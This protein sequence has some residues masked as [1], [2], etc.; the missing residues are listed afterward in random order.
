MALLLIAPVLAVCDGKIKDV[1]A[2]YSSGSY[3]DTARLGEAYENAAQCFYDEGNQ[4]KTEYYYTLAANAYSSTAENLTQDFN[5]KASLY[6][7]AGNDYLKAKLPLLAMES[8]NKTI[9]LYNEHPNQVGLDK[10]QH[11]RQEVE[12]LQNPSMKIL[13]TAEAPKDEFNMILV[14]L[15]VVAV[16]GFLSVLFYL[17]AR[18]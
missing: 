14:A 18:K 17:K 12:K 4:E 1:E 3:S 11:A 16:F 8:F 9:E 10:V 15:L 13:M 5:I 6:V 7:S 2:K